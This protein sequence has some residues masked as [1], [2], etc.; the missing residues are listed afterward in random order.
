MATGRNANNYLL[1]TKG[2][3]KVFGSLVANS[4][5]DM[6]VKQSS[7]HAILGENGAGKSTLMKMLYGVYAPDGGTIMMDD[8]EVELHP[9]TKARAKGIG[10]VFQDFRVVPALT[11]LDNIALAV[12]KGFSFNRKK[13]KKRI[14]EIST[15]YGLAVDPEAYVWQLDLGQRQ[16]LEIVKVLLAEGTK[17][18]IFDEP[19]SVLV[20]Q[21][22]EAFLNMLKMLRED[23]YGILLITHKINEVLAVADQVSVLRSGVLTYSASKEDGLTAD[24][25][26]AAMMGNKELK[27]V[28]KDTNNIFSETSLQI[29][30]GTIKGDYGEI[31]IQDIDFTVKKGQIV[32]IAGI[33]GSGQRE[34]AEVL[35]G[36]RKLVKGSIE[37][38]GQACKPDVRTFL[39]AGVSFVSED[40]IKES[41]I[42]GFSILE[43]MILDGMPMKKKSMGI[44]WKMLAQ[45]LQLSKEANSLALADGQRH[46]DTLS[47]GNV[48]RMVLTRALI[49]TPEVLVI[50]YPSRGLDIGTTRTIQQHLVE[51]AEQ[52]TAIV[53][54]SED[55]DELFKLSDELVVLSGKR[56][57]QPYET[58][59]TDASQI[60]QLMLK[61][62]S[63]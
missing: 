6:V 47:G 5:I 10:M 4:D 42:P 7:I 62:E 3:T 34:L 55:L 23:G 59:T 51:L 49:R 46:A 50:S 18:I 63:T 54:F 25:L 56:I 52:G 8:Q 35:F 61:G 41:V 14:I 26:I 22:V 15:K 28:M 43:H 31:V 20:P 37:L 40:P 45:E 38:K 1:K 60:G 30:S 11:I 13:L 32:G 39:E 36:L 17:I 9:P 33:S 27:T 53:L 24:E 21:E 44:D 2:L 29:K 58:A 48:Q 12:E 19:T 57:S 16:R